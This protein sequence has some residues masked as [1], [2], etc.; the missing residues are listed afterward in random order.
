MAPRGR[1]LPNTEIFRLLAAEV[2]LGEPALFDDDETLL[3][4]YLD[5]Y[6]ADVRDRLL[7]DGYAR[8]ERETPPAAK[9]LLRSETAAARWGV[10][11]LPQGRDDPGG[12]GLVLLTPKAHHFLNSSLVNHARLRKAAGR[13]VAL[14]SPGDAEEAGVADGAL[15][16]LTN[17]RGTVRLPAA[18]SADVLAGT[19]VVLDNWWH[20]DMG[21]RGV[22]ALTGQDLTDLGAGPIFTARVRLAPA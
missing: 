8:I 3:A 21:G 7:A 14:V 13:P 15:A 5:G 16:C 18:H 10:D 4:T 1:A 9:A 12:D 22:N 11:P 2:G 19:V 17:D 6:P 20:A